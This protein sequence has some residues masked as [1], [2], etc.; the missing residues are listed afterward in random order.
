MNHPVMHH[1]C[2][3]LSRCS[4]WEKG[5]AL[6][7]HQIV[8][9]DQIESICNVKERDVTEENEDDEDGILF[10][11]LESRFGNKETVCNWQTIKLSCLQY[12]KIR[13][14]PFSLASLTWSNHFRTIAEVCKSNTPAANI[15]LQSNVC[16]SYFKQYFT[17]LLGR[18]SIYKYNE[19]CNLI[20]S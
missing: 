6:L 16:T 15:M 8:Q 14:A 1:R 11:I 2:L 7:T 13:K 9:P 3:V 12:K 4:Q 19:Y 17:F 18:D 10:A 20:G 5:R